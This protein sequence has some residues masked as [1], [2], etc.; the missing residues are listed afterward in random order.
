MMASQD[1]ENEPPQ[2]PN[3]S[4]A[5]SA[6]TT[7]G[8]SACEANTRTLNELSDRIKGRLSEGEVDME[9]LASMRPVLDES[10]RQQ[11]L[12]SNLIV[13]LMGHHTNK[14]MARAASQGTLDS[15]LAV[16]DGFEVKDRAAEAAA[17]EQ[18]MKMATSFLAA[19]GITIDDL[20]RAAQ[21]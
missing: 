21:Q 1:A 6:L 18:K 16:I 20:Q 4:M 9:L 3:G 11:K 5:M 19:T 15:C 12:L 7:T 17:E 2:D 14:A 13:H 8:L 10:E